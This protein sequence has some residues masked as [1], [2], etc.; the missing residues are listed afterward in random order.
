MHYAIK[1]KSAPSAEPVTLAQAKMHAK[2]DHSYE[3]DLIET[4][5]SAARSTAEKY[6]QRALITQTLTMTLDKFP[7]Y[8]P[9]V[10]E[11]TYSGYR[12]SVIYLPRNPVQSV[13]EVRYVDDSG[14][15]QTLD[16]S[17]YRVDT[18]SEPARITPVYDEL[19]PSTRVTIKT[20][21]V[22]YI[23]GYGAADTD[24][25]A[26]IR[27]AILMMVSTWYNIRQDVAI[28]VSTQK[29]PHSAEHLM[30]PYRV[31]TA[32]GGLMP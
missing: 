5:I 29:I 13:S 27:L 4:I 30:G 22:D 26:N 6:L 21:E 3:D 18:D 25:P 24:V 7:G 14:V 17:R 19:W 2:I 8:Q 28:G 16:A 10:P 1:V 32:G 11:L 31:A 23:A 15:T 9:F 12:E 20:V